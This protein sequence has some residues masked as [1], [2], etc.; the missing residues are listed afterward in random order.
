MDI[1][2]AV[3]Q[4]AGVGR[5]AR[6]LAESM[7][8]FA[9]ADELT[10][11]HF[12]F[13]A[14]SEPV[15][16][17]RARVRRVGWCPGRVAQKAWNTFGWPSFDFW[18]G[19]ADLFFFPNFVLP[20]VRKGKT[21]VTI[22][23][24][25]YVRFPEF[26]EDRN[27]RYLEARLPRTV[28][29]ADAII[30]VSR[31]SAQEISEILKVH[32]ARIYPVYHGISEHFKRPDAGKIASALAHFSI[33]RPYLLSVGTIEP[34]KNIP[35][36]IKFFESLADF[37][38]KLVVAGMPGWKYEPIIDAMRQSSRAKDILYL[39]YVGNIHLPAL[40]AGTEAFL[41]PSFYEGF[42]FPPLEAM[43]CGAP[44][45]SSARGSLPEVLGP[46]AVLLDEFD[47]DAWGAAL[48]RVMTDTDFRRQLTQTGPEWASRFKWRNTARETWDVFRRVFA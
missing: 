15:E 13:R 19:A 24:M 27:R 20:P 34:R 14:E 18:A 37:D 35:F 11:F 23:D 22:H 2:S 38:G 43:A 45:I 32:P 31:F 39:R 42:G 36:L 4:T 1:Q 7:G 9:E 6:M 40:Y 21:A 26:A 16:A 5:Y 41:L 33:D 44:V 46:G 10:L 48:R 28:E 3:A 29:Q 30:T 25:S 47:C 17:P 12:D 8:E